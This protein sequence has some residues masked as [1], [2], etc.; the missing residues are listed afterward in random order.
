MSHLFYRLLL[1]VVLLIGVSLA[2]VYRDAFNYQTIQIWVEQA[3]YIAP[4]IFIIIYVLATI[5]FLPGS[6]ITLLG[7]ALFGPVWGVFY[8]L[9]AATIGAVLAFLIARYLTSDLVAKKSGKRIKQLINGVENEGWRFVAFVRLVPLFPFN[10]LNYAL[11]LTKIRLIDYAITTYICMFP[12]AI[13]Y[14]YLGY[15]GREAASGGDDIIHK[16]LLAIALLAI[17]IF[18]PRM[19][20]NFRYQWV[21]ATEL[22]KMLDNNKDILLL[23]V[24]TSEDFNGEN[25]HISGAVSIPLEQLEEKIDKLSENID[26]KII[27]ICQTDRKS[28]KAANLLIKNNFTNVYIAKMGMSDW[29]NQDYPTAEIF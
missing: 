12:G 28:K 13:A 4:L 17:V 9:T 20:Q 8:N 27:L 14:T 19:I 23:D 24:R 16:A 11:G 3:G 1:F 10:L 5:F 21:S 29:V 18:F 7:G 15:I 25:K 6:V 26:K 2:I 22:K